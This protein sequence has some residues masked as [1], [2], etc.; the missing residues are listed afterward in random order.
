M[1]INFA[2]P[3]NLIFLFVIPVIIFFHFFGLK[4]LKGKSLKFA[5]FEAIGRVKG[6]DLY[7]KNLLPLIFDIFFV[8]ILVFGISGMTLHKEITASEFSYVIAVDTSESMTARDIEPNRLEAAKEAAIKF[9]TSTNYDMK[10]AVIS[11]AGDS[12]IEEGLTDDKKLLEESI[13]NIEPSEIS[14]TDVYD[15]V[16]ISAHLLKEEKNKAI[17]LI[18]DGQINVGDF[19]EV[20]DYSQ[21]SGVLVHS[22]A[23]GTAEGGDVSFGVSKIDEDSLKSISYNTDGEFYRITDRTGLEN[24]FSNILTITRIPGEIDLTFYLVI[25]VIGLFVFRQFLMSINKIVW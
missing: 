3:T 4:N 9:I 23:I 12:I 20:I 17:I 21:Q 14:G 5:N 8:V 13:R 11:F 2:I 16:L 1:Y 19:D 15:A 24:S 6:I 25:A 10:V 18:S 22:I 7:S